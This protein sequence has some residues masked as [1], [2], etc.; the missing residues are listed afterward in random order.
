MLTKSSLAVFAASHRCLCP[1][2]SLLSGGPEDTIS[3]PERKPSRLSRRCGVE[4]QL[5][6]E[7]GCSAPGSAGRP[8][9]RA[10][11]A[12]AGR[13]LDVNPHFEESRCSITSIVRLFT[14]LCRGRGARHQKSGWKVQAHGSA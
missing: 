10:R 5:K 6:S 9:L 7:K 1:A 14:C 2:I 4:D 13:P 12:A 8:T 3:W 11:E